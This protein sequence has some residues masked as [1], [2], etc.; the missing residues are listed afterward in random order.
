[1]PSVAEIVG[2][3]LLGWLLADLVAGIF[4]WWEDEIG[5]EDW[6]VL[7]PWLIAPN[8]LHHK[9]PLAFTQNSFWHRNRAACIAAVCIGI[10]WWS[11]FGPSIMMASALVGG[12]ISNE[13]HYYAHKPSKGGKIVRLLQ[14]VGIFQSP[15][16]H[17]MHHRPPHDKCF[18]VNTD[19]LNPILN[20]MRFWNLARAVCRKK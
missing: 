1:M 9:D 3:L 12:A 11:A 6:A 17:A 7:G 2:Q 18:C 5:K 16:K 14:D 19:W 20:Q 10:I 13:I 15:K 8:R 4:H